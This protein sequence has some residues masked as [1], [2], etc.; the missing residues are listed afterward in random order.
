[1][2]QQ[3]ALM[4]LNEI[5]QFMSVISNLWGQ[6]VGSSPQ[7]GW[8]NLAN[9][10]KRNRE[11][12]RIPPNILATYLNLLSKH[13]NFKQNFLPMWQLWPI[14]KKNSP[15]HLHFL[16]TNLLK[17]I[18]KLNTA[19]HQAFQGFFFVIENTALQRRWFLQ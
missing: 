9:R 7:G 2:F 17:F 8:A 10:S 4:M 16:V 18:K 12:F 19:L 5:P 11:Q 3:L 6:W 13:E 1:M 15:L 14:F